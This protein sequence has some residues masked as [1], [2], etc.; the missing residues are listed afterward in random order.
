MAPEGI[1]GT[2]KG[3]WHWKGSV[4]PEGI[5]STKKGQ[6]HQKGL[7]ALKKVSGD[8]HECTASTEI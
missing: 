5:Y 8:V 1:S 7:T 6:W 3:Q 2:K 4:A